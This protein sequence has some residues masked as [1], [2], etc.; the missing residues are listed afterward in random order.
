MKKISDFPM[1]DKNPWD[2]EGIWER[3]KVQQGGE[4]IMEDKTTGDTFVLKPAIKIKGSFMK[5]HFAYRKLFKNN[6][7]K[8]KNL[9]IP[10][11]RLFCYILDALDKNIDEIRINVDEARSF[12]NFRSPTQY[13]AGIADLLEREFI[14]RKSDDRM[15]FYI[16][17]NIF[18]N[19]DRTKMLSDRENEE[20]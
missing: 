8:V 19:G 11:L 20:P 12:C 5:D 1:Y 3:L 2:P 14:V 17:V 9:T 15:L 16:N 6:L 4:R 18:F 7:D 10:G 13:Y